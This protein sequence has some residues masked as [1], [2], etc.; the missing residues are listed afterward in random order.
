MAETAE[1]HSN[2]FFLEKQTHQ[3]VTC[4]AF[5]IGVPEKCLSGIPNSEEIVNS[6]LKNDDA[7]IIRSLC[8]IRSNLMTNWATTDFSITYSFTNL[9][10]QEIFKKDSEELT[11]RKIPFIQPNC[12]IE[13]YV[14]RCN[15][16]IRKHID[17][18]SDL[19][20]DWLNWSFIKEIFMMP[21]G[22]TSKGI[23]LAK[24]K[25]TSRISEYPFQKYINF[26]I[27]DL[28]NILH[29]DEKFVKCLYKQHGLEFTDYSKL[30]KAPNVIKTNIFRFLDNQEKVVV[31]VDCENSDVFKLASAIKQLNDKNLH[32]I[33]KIVL[34]DDVHTTTA[35]KHLQTITGIP[36][37]YVLVNRVTERKSLVDMRMCSEV[38]KERYLNNVKSFIL[39][40]SD[41]DF[42]GL[43]SSLNEDTNFLVL[44]EGNKCGKD[45]KQALIDNETYYCNLDNFGTAAVADLKFNIIENSLRQVLD[46]LPLYNL[47]DLLEGCY[48]D[49][50]VNVSPE[51][52]TNHFKKFSSRIS[53]KL[54]ES[55]DYVFN[56]KVYD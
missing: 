48:T 52:K 7:V 41:S 32:K 9:D 53:F 27:Q 19:F 47:K 5:L 38:T 29:T 2:N 24:T 8:S 11:K 42:W 1:N 25:F 54:T 46:S 44:V 45:I 12:K 34:F 23:K 17:K 36:V 40:S 35:W 10:K 22:S 13:Q 50:K 3:I 18:I 14:I 30:K 43:I 31:A 55:G 6:L 26:G 4:I 16:F 21:D 20:P 33:Q 37:E 28:G 15:F 56:L 49:L 51:E 39:V